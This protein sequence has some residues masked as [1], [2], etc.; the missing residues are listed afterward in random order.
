V[1]PEPMLIN[2]IL[3]MKSVSGLKELFSHN[4]I[5]ASW[6]HD[7]S[8]NYWQAAVW[9]VCLILLKCGLHEWRRN[10]YKRVPAINKLYLYSCILSRPEG[11]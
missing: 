10:E 2:C 9:Q 7:R 5:P 3:L 11:L 4:P 6:V 1:L 8:S